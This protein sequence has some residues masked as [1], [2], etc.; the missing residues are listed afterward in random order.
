MPPAYV[1]HDA[2]H[3]A[4]PA[5]SSA[6]STLASDATASA[7]YE[8]RTSHSPSS[9]MRKPPSAVFIRSRNERSLARSRH[10][11][12]RSVPSVARAH[13]AAYV[14]ARCGACAGPPQKPPAPSWQRERK[15]ATWSASS[16]G[17]LPGA[18]SSSECTIQ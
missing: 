4:A 17:T 14:G 11:Y 16:A 2:I 7:V 3:S 8:P 9:C 6:S 5:A 12:A 1:W 13:T 18:M 10:A 15:P